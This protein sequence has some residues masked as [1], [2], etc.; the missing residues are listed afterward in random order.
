MSRESS[1]EEGIRSHIFVKGG[2]LVCQLRKGGARS[3]NSCRLLQ[4][5]GI[6]GVRD[7]DALAL[8]ASEALGNDLPLTELRDSSDGDPFFLTH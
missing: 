2:E 8:H 5:M 6:E 4:R 7:G 1:I 3:D